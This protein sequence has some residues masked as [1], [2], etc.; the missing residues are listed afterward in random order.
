MSNDLMIAQIIHAIPRQI[1]AK[2]HIF[3][4]ERIHGITIFQFKECICLLV[5]LMLTK[6]CD[7]LVELTVSLFKRK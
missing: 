5:S 6:E 2:P 3:P 4:D 7:N 1:C